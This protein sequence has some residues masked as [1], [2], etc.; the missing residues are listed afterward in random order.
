MVAERCVVEIGSMSDMKS[1]ARPMPSEITD[2]TVEVPSPHILAQA[3]LRL[4][5]LRV[6][7][8]DCLVHELQ[9]LADRS[10]LGQHVCQPLL[11][12]G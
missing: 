6:E 8:S 9:A 5:Q 4:Q 2:P 11:S 7:G 3:L 10:R 1:Q 12:K